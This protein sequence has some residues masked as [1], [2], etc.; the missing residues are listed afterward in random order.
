MSK[1]MWMVRA[2]NGNALIDIFLEDSIV[3][4]GWEHVGDLNG[5]SKENIKNIV[6]KLSPNNSGNIS[7]YSQLN[8]F[9]NEIFIED[10]VITYD[11]SARQYHVGKVQS[12]YNFDL[13]QNIDYPHSRKVKW[14]HKIDR[15]ILDSASKNTLG[16]TLTIFQINKEVESDILNK[17]KHPNILP[18]SDIETKQSDA[19][20]QKNDV[21]GKSFEYTKDILIK[22]DPDQMEELV[23]G[24]IRGT[25]LEAQRTPKGKDR[26]KDI[27]ASSD[28]LGLGDIKIHV[29]VKHRKVKMG[30]DEIRKFLGGLRPPIKGLFVSTGGFT[31]EAKYEAERSNI[32]ITLMDIDMLVEHI[33]KN[34]E[35][36]DIDT[37]LLL[38]LRKIY[39]PE[40]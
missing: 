24:L 38:P 27:V 34:Y 18:K 12:D 30:S 10:Y 32:P 11:S 20:F 26:G 33:F 37:R 17:S 8:K 13:A 7:T 35:N 14:L 21:I 36:F 1:N 25:G 19:S 28:G 23:A 3:A 22:F 6:E 2:G 9:V 39:W 16:S 31:Q 40:M 29:E 15:D 5:E 4:I